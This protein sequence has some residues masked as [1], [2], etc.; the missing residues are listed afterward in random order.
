[1]DV[2]TA[3][4]V[5]LE[6]FAVKTLRIVPLAH[7]GRVNRRLV[8][9]RGAKLFYV[10]VFDLLHSLVELG[11]HMRQRS[12]LPNAIERY[13]PVRHHKHQSSLMPEYPLKFTKCRDGIRQVLDDMTG[14]YGVQGAIGDGG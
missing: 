4:A 1:M 10:L 9:D 12:W 14:D 8:V 5:Q 6:Q 2:N 13:V 3:P 7:N 11:Q